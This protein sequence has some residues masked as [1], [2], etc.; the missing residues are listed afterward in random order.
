MTTK[1]KNIIGSA[2][3]VWIVLSHTSTSFKSGKWG[4]SFLC[5]CSECGAE[6]E[7]EA[8]IFYHPPICN[9]KCN[10]KSR[11][12][13]H[14][15]S[16]TDVYK[17]WS[18]MKGRC[19]TKT[20]H[21]Y[22]R[23]GGIGVTICDKWLKFEGFYGDMGDRPSEIHSIDRKDGTKGYSKDN[24]RWATPKEQANNRKDNR[25]VS[26]FGLTKN[27]GEWAD[28]Y[29]MCKGMLKYRLDQGLPPETA[30]TMPSVRGT[31][32]IK[33]IVKESNK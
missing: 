3:G 33:D 32:I 1:T 6:K 26:A 31:N 7:I 4:K 23:Y 16:R 28:E 10:K 24:C 11:K 14:G 9:N 29:G 8:K 12:P 18:S 27:L 19:L 21:H 30:L 25:K 20:N 15:M 22:H 13:I 2:Y 17:I 5:R